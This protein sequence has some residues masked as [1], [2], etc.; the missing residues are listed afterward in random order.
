M[1]RRMVAAIVA[2]LGFIAVGCGVTP[3]RLNAR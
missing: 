1:R 2:V 3:D